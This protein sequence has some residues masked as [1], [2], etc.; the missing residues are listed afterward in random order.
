[1][2]TQFDETRWP[3]LTRFRAA[4]LAD[5]YHEMQAIADKNHDWYPNENPD[6]ISMPKLA[7]VYQAQYFAGTND[8]A[9]LQDLL[10]KDPWVIN[11]PWTAQGWLPITQA[12][13]SHGDR[14][15]IKYLLQ[16]GADPSLEVGSPDDRATV[17]EMARM[18]GHEDLANW[19]EDI[20][21]ETR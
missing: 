9:G 10:E 7:R 17:V 13:G 12:A 1:M 16:M 6:G 21:D 5:R 15:L 3:D 2:Q 18:G 19:L 20:I 14:T 8:L 4:C 11:Y